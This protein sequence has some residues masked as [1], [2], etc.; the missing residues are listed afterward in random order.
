MSRGFLF[1]HLKG[2]IKFFLY[3][4]SDRVKKLKSLQNY[5][6]DA[7]DWT[8]LICSA[9]RPHDHYATETN[10]TKQESFKNLKTNDP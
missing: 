2:V 5:N 6:A 1:T 9:R 7:G 8:Q 4:G 3:T 10:D